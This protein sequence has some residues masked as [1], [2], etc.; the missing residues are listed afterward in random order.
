MVDRAVD[1]ARRNK[2]HRTVAVRIV[3]SLRWALCIRM[4]VRGSKTYGPLLAAV[5]KVELRLRALD[6]LSRAEPPSEGPR[7]NLGCGDDF[8]QG[9]I[10][11]DIRPA[12][13]IIADVRCLPLKE[14]S[15]SVIVAND[16]LEHF[17][18][19]ETPG[20]LR[21]WHRVLRPWGLL[22]VKVPNMWWLS[23]AL[24]S[25][26]R[27]VLPAME[28]IY[29]GHRFGPGGLWDTHHWGW[30]PPLLESLLRDHGFVPVSNDHGRN[31]TIRAVKVP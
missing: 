7:V 19:L 14:G 31:M 17:W 8:R 9:W 16:I 4:P 15:V 24:L 18:H 1:I 11:I 28:N 6:E 30:T 13:N 10:N 5:A 26:K 3:A 20:L 29:G 23:R 21:E 25:R 27:S 2:W 12:G 22:E